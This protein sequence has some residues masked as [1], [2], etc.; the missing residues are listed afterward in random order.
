MFYPFSSKIVLIFNN[1]LGILKI[2]FSLTPII[3]IGL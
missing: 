3:S 1:F 2:F